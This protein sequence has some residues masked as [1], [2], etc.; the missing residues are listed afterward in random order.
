[1]P[2][3]RGLKETEVARAVEMYA[4]GTSLVDVAEAFG[5]TTTTT[6]NYLREREVASRDTQRRHCSETDVPP[7]HGV[8]R[9]RVGTP[10][11]SLPS[12]GFG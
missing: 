3:F 1:M 5:V 2:G 11:R 10:P 7:F 9:H 6:R 8:S 4:T 12:F